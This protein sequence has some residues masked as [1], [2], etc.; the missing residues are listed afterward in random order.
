LAGA[1]LAV[2]LRAVVFF[3]TATVPPVGRSLPLGRALRAP[4]LQIRRPI[5]DIAAISRPG[6]SRTTSDS[7][8]C[9]SSTESGPL[10]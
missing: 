7:L 10:M 9:Y 6:V 2:R 4:L 5:R 8:S 3:A 1:F